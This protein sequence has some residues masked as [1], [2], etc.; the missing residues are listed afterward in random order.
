MKFSEMTEWL[1]H[2]REGALNSDF[3]EMIENR[4]VESLARITRNPVAA[5]IWGPAPQSGTPVANARIQLQDELTKLGH[6]ARFSEE[7]IDPTSKHSIFAQQVAQAEAYDIVF[8]IP[9]S[10]GSIAEIHDFARI[11][12]LSHKIVAFVNVDW[13]SGYS[14]KSL[15]Q[16]QSNFT[17][18]IKPYSPS[19]LPNCIID[20]SIDLVRRLQ[21]CF[22][23]NGRRF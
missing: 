20:T 17:C 3:T 10:P 14:N 13:D 2:Q 15:L 11:P 12:Q 1:L 21:E 8:S 18:Q 5:L 7:L 22:Y 19:E 4:L 16:A 9:S 23:V 6:L